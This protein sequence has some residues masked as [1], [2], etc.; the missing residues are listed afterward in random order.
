MLTVPKIFSDL[1]PISCERFSTLSSQLWESAPKPYEACARSCLN[2]SVTWK[3]CIKVVRESAESCRQMAG[4]YA[5]QGIAAQER[6]SA[7]DL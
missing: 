3:R 6:V 4:S 1:R 2:R 7:D 5:N